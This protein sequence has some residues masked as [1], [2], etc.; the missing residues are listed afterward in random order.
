M[1]H[2][3]RRGEERPRK[4]AEGIDVYGCQDRQS[5][6]Q[7]VTSSNSEMVGSSTP[8]TAPSAGQTS[9]GTKAQRRFSGV[10]HALKKLA[11]MEPGMGNESRTIVAFCSASYSVHCEGAYG[12]CSSQSRQGRPEI[13]KG[14][15]DGR[16]DLL[17]LFL[18]SRGSIIHRSVRSTYESPLFFFSSPMVPHLEV[19]Q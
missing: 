10:G 1:K 3:G 12:V 9:K 6:C 2:R 5:Y 4:R 15:S 18:Q 13:E 16:D 17:H 19:T 8:N 7:V 14:G 11:G